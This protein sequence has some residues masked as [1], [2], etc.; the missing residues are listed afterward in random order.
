MATEALQEIM[1]ALRAKE[2]GCPW[3][4]EQ[5]F[6]TIAPYTIEEAYEVADAIAQGDMGELRSELGDLLFQVVFHSQMAEE[7]GH[8]TFD[9]VVSTICEKMTRRH[10]HVFSDKEVA[11]AEEQSHAW[12]QHKAVE[13]LQKQADGEV[14]HL[15]GIALALPALLRA[16]KLQKRAARV[17]FDWPELDG[18]IDKI[19]EELA[20]L[21]E[22]IAEGESKQRVSEE[23]GDLLF[24]V[25]NLARRL[26]IDAETTVRD[27]NQKFEHRFAYIEQQLS[28]AG[29]SLEEASLQEMDRLWNE[30]KSE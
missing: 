5:T 24:S 3:D 29:I 28:Q 17:G 7:G 13:R 21:K 14:S 12:E 4:R 16:E 9:D 18:V 20:E 2:G 30:A 19:D 6:K 11:N 22:A 27:T 26:K 15:S 25:A 1:R 10:P 8:F 23:M